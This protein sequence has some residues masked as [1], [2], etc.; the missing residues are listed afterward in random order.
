VPA[1]APEPERR[2]EPELEPEV[3][4]DRVPEPEPEPEPVSTGPFVQ[5]RLGEWKITDVERLLAQEGPRYPDRLAE[6]AFYVETFRDVAESDGRLPGGVEGI[7]EDVF[8]DLIGS[9]ER[10]RGERG[11]R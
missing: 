10:G 2:P 8:G 5:P 9:A 3:E 6:L 7:V 4:P 11:P 1:P